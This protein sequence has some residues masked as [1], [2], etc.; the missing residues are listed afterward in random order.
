[1]K[2][3]VLLLFIPAMVFCQN[4]QIHYDFGHERNYITTTFEMFKSDKYGATFWFIDMDFDHGHR[5]SMSLAYLEFARYFGFSSINPFSLTLQYNDGTSEFG[6]LGQVWLSG[7]SFS[8]SMAR[9]NLAPELLYR[10][11]QG[12]EKADLQF[13]LVWLLS[14]QDV[15]VAGYVDVWTQDKST[16]TKELAVQAEPQIWYNLNPHFAIG[17][18]LEIS[19][20]FLPTDQWEFMPTAAFRYTF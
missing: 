6:S 9:L 20:N 10:H 13:T 11:Q 12:A 8:F 2:N 1:M 14:Y 5:K 19:K 7:I 16:T 17:S 4:V 15:D 18:E 3:I